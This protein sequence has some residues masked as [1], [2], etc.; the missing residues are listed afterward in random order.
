[1]GIMMMKLVF[2]NIAELVFGLFI[3][4]LITFLTIKYLHNN[5][6][7]AEPEPAEGLAQFTTFKVGCLDGKVVIV[8]GSG[9]QMLYKYNGQNIMTCEEYNLINNKKGIKHEQH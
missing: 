9:G 6:A 8:T 2:K 5:E 7:H 4:L 1:M 3:V